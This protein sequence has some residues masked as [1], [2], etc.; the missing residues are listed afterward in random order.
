MTRNDRAAQRARHGSTGA[1]N[2]VL[3]ALAAVTAGALGFGIVMG[4]MYWENLSNSFTT[5]DI[6]GLVGA[7]VT[8]D[9]ATPTATADATPVDSAA[10]NDVNIL[11]VG[12]DSRSG[13]NGD[14]G[15]K[16]TEGMR[17]DT[18]MIMH[19]S[20][21]RSRI[22]FLSVPRDMRVRVSDCKMLD[23]STVK[24][25]TGK[26][27][28][29]FANGGK[30]GNEAEGAACTMKTLQDL[31]GIT[32]DH[33][34]VVD[35]AGFEK[36][37]NAVD[38]VP[39]CIPENIDDR[40]SKL[41]VKAGARVLNG[42]TALAYARVRHIGDGTDL[43]RIE[44]QQDLM[45]NLAKKVL[46]MNVLTDAPQLTLLLKSAGESMTMDP[47]LGSLTYLLGLG[48]SLRN[49]DQNNINFMTV[50][51][52]YAGDKSGDVLAKDEAKTVYKRIKNDIPMDGGKT[53][54]ADPST[55][56]DPSTSTSASPTPERLTED[57]ILAA[58]K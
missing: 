49:I 3:R 39:M 53:Q 5:Q 16:V 17:S 14:I 45:T 20:A 24:G 11:L 31:T 34:A 35:F 47:E 22:D 46:G 55:S 8:T 9:S 38:G 10:G 32:F 21:D 51:W 42:K 57:E 58:C 1:G 56:P 6:S 4:T 12:S 27:N 15:G 48:Y 28:I 18:T 19:I 33:Y 26:F 13:A 52:Q 36:M 40:R 44:R 54:S 2:S 43:Q 23:G 29:A 7:P 41:H 30:N 25:W 37:I 50:P